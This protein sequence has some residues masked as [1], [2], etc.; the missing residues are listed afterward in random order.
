MLEQLDADETTVAFESPRRLAATLAALAEDEPDRPV[1]VCREL[2]KLHEEVRRGSASD[3]AAHYAASPARGEVTLVVGASSKPA[4][5]PR[6]AQDALERLIAAGAR[7][8]AAAQALA[9]VTGLRAKDLYDGRL[10]GK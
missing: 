7:P 2:T 5:D 10:G 4:A 3:L 9:E 8:R 1:T 6:R